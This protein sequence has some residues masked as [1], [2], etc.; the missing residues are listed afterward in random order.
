MLE[1]INSVT[2]TGRIKQKQA[3]FHNEGFWAGITSGL[4]NGKFKFH[5]KFV[6]VE[7]TDL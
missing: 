7:R 3:Q 1:A 4:P 6:G 2:S 5:T